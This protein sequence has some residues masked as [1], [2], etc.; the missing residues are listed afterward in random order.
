LCK[1]AA[2]EAVVRLISAIIGVGGADA[3][4]RA[5]ALSRRR[6][7]LEMTEPESLDDGAAAAE[8]RLVALTGFM[9]SGKTSV[10]RE[11]ASVLGWKFV[12]LDELIETSEGTTIPELFRDKGEPA[13][14]KIECKALAAFLAQQSEPTV[15]ALGGGAWVQPDTAGLLRQGW[16]KTVFLEV[17]VE[18]LFRRCSEDS[19]LSEANLRPLA[20]D[21]GKF[22]EL[23]QQRLPHYRCANLTVRSGAAPADEIAREIAARLLLEMRA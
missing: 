16:M 10:G 9:G 7:G 8:V 19:A 21:R 6:A 3:R 2:V 22:E 5:D 4:I 11:L 17:E 23:H 18:E 14:R 1:A 13:F 12:D 15:L 20:Q